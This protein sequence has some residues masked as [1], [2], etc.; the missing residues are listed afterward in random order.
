MCRSR[1]S[2][3]GPGF[4]KGRST[5]DAIRRVLE[6]ERDAIE[7]EIWKFGTKE[8]CAVAIFDV[9]NAFTQRIGGIL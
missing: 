1:R 6:I 4:R 7:G 5:V 9:R 8:Y 3:L 2:F